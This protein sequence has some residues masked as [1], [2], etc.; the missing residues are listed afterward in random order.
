MSQRRSGTTLLELLVVIGI[1]LMLS[2]LILPAALKTRE[3]AR[4]TECKNHL[5][6]MAL[7]FRLYADAH[8]DRFPDVEGEPWYM[9]IAP[10]LEMQEQIFY[11]PSNPVP[12]DLGYDWRDEI[13]VLPS[14]FLSKK[15]YSL[16]KDTDLILVFDHGMEWHAPG[17]VNAA[18]VNGSVRS[19]PMEEFEENLLFSPETG[20]L[21][22]EF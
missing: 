18:M 1:V 22:L 7:G 10:H 19:V 6:Q 13:A 3:A 16:V 8:H 14:A 15:K 20:D 4:S 21:S 5:R 12:D 17:Q 2:A 9:Q 11:C